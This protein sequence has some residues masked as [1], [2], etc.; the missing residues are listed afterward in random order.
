M[1]LIPQT[2]KEQAKRTMAIITNLSNEVN[3]FFRQNDQTDPPLD[4]TYKAG[5]IAAAQGEFEELVA[6]AKWAVAHTSFG[7]SDPVA[8][9]DAAMLLKDP[10]LLEFDDGT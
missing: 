4:A 6:A 7:L 5:R 1:A 10:E 9:D 8:L 2:N 3:K